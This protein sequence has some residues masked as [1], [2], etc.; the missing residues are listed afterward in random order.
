M[1]KI[2]ILFVLFSHTSFWTGHNKLDVWHESTVPVSKSFGVG[3]EFIY[4]LHTKPEKVGYG[5][6]FAY[7]RVNKVVRIAVGKDYQGNPVGQV[8]LTTKLGIGK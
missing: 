7:Y 4:D 6:L 8:T 1:K 3:T 2:L 5:Y